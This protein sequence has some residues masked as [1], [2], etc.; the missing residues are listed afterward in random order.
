MILENIDIDAFNWVIVD[1]HFYTKNFSQGEHFIIEYTDDLFYYTVAEYVKGED[2]DNEQFYNKSLLMLRYNHDFSQSA[3]WRFRATTNSQSD[4][5]FIDQ[6][7]ITG[8]PEVV[9]LSGTSELAMP[10]NLSLA[11][12]PARDYIRIKTLLEG[13]LNY[14]IYNLLGQVVN[15][16]IYNG[17]EIPVYDLSAGLYFLEINNG[18]QKSHRKFI[19]E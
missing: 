15:K 16:G 7:T 9:F 19:K 8:N 11:P 17:I 14:T 2:F 1:F 6:V 4:Q 13:D 3:S 5:V 18:I 10:P 12:N